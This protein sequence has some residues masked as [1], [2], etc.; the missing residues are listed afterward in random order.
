M[1]LK[2]YIWIL[3]QILLTWIPDDQNINYGTYGWGNGLSPI[4]WHPIITW[5][6]PSC[7]IASLGNNGLNAQNTF[8]FKLF[9]KMANE[10]LWHSNCQ[11]SINSDVF[12][13]HFWTNHAKFDIPNQILWM[14][15]LKR[16]MA[17]TT[18]SAKYW[19]HTLA[20]CVKVP[21]Q[22][23]RISEATYDPFHKSVWA[24]DSNFVKKLKEKKIII[25][26]TL[27]WKLTTRSDHNFAHAMTAQ[28]SW[29][30]QNNDL[31]WS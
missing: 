27:T 7:H 19:G 24:D 28:L 17:C 12:F 22:W 30:V 5:I 21:C 3:I 20:T 23:H 4:Q 1:I 2:E 9:I 10:I 29:H 11:C 13:L 8:S 16:L 6:N 25:H 26:L 31:M 15:E 18:C 14:L